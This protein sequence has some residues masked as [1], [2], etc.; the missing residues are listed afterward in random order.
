MDAGQEV[1]F[2]SGNAGDGDAASGSPGARAGTPSGGGGRSRASSPTA[3]MAHKRLIDDIRI[4]ILREQMEQL[5]SERARI[6]E[7]SRQVKAEN[8]ERLQDQADIYYYLNK[9]LDSYYEIVNKLEEQIVKEQSERESAEKDYEKIIEKLHAKISSEELKSSSKI[10]ELED[11][12]ELSRKFDE[13]KPL[14]EAEISEL[15]AQL[16]ESQE[17]G[18]RT[19]DEWEKRLVQEKR[20]LRQELEAEMDALRASHAEDIERK[21]SLKTRK[22]KIA[23]ALYRKELL[24]QVGFTRRW[25]LLLYYHKSPVAY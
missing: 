19:S 21:L 3:V 2:A 22:T 13:Q 10:A 20:R 5:E 18:K 4:S 17:Y 7:E 8:R 23:N 15:K 11:K 9:K 12:L 14:L 16:Q 24:H 1:R 25:T 6:I